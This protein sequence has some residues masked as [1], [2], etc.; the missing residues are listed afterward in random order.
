[1]KRFPLEIRRIFPKLL[2]YGTVAIRGVQ[3]C[4]YHTLRTKVLRIAT[5]LFLH[6]G[7]ALTTE[8]ATS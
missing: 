2:F 8:L 4:R 6:H 3:A 1:M 5:V 7:P